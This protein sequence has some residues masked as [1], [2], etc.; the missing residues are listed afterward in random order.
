MIEKEN[1]PSEKILVFLYNSIQSIKWTTKLNF[2]LCGE[3]NKNTYVGFINKE[4]KKYWPV[5]TEKCEDIKEN[6]IKPQR[7]SSEVSSYIM[8]KI[9][10][11]LRKE[12]DY[13]YDIT[14]TTNKIASSILSN[15]NNA[16]LNLI[17]FNNISKR[18]YSALEVKSE[19]KEVLYED[20]NKVIEIYFKKL[21]TKGYIDY[22]ISIYLYNKYLLEDE[23][24]KKQIQERFEYLIV[25][26]F[27][28]VSKAQL[29][30][31]NTIESQLKKSYLFFNPLGGNFIFN[32]SDINYIKS[33]L[34][35]KHKSVT[36]NE[37]FTCS[38]D[39][40]K[41]SQILCAKINNEDIAVKEKIPIS[42]DVNS[43]LRSE[44]ILKVMLKVEN[45]L[46]EGKHVEDIAIITPFKDLSINYEIEKLINHI[47]LEKDNL[48]ETVDRLVDNEYIHA[49][50]VMACMYKKSKSIK[51]TEDDYNNLFSFLFEIDLVR[52]SILTEALLNKNLDEISEERVGKECIKKYENFKKWIKDCRKEDMSLGE[53][54]RKAYLEILINMPCAKENIVMCKKIFESAEKF[55]DVIKGF[56]GDKKSCD[57]FFIFAVSKLKNF[58]SILEIEEKLL[59]N[60]ITISTPYNYITSS[61]HNKIQIWVDVNSE[62]W[63][64]RNIRNLSNNYVLK[65]SWQE[66]NIYNDEIESNNIRSNICLLIERLLARCSEKVYMYGSEYSIAGYQQE[67]I[68]ASNVMEIINEKD[69]LNGK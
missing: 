35:I 58:K 26:D 14:S 45:L 9:I 33:N 30:F 64:P 61:M 7:V 16:A 53:F 4:L 5:V 18:L 28:E 60:E 42:I 8:E 21:I 34:K 19:T 41:I 25:D 48:N 17:P 44:M 56:Y 6:F 13:F 63:C 62:T 40:I 50:I 10:D 36:L 39:L 12:K 20:M 69:E 38:K 37:N 11:D 49:L 27:N 29:K 54:F 23:L 65:N 52:S 3:V 68:L 32:G 57:E 24:Y 51:I 43:E 1:I 59:S 55:M 31:I 66:E 67:N 15:M 22:A 47:G 2:N 46:K